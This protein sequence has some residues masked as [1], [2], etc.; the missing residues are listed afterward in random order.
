MHLSSPSPVTAA[1][2]KFRGVGFR[3]ALFEACLVFTTRY[4]L[5]TR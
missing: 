5:L 1:F 4:G 3:I 2:L